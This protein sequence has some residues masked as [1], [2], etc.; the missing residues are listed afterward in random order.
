[1]AG[2]NQVLAGKAGA[3]DAVL[4]A[5]RAHIGN[6]GMSEKA[7]WA[8]LNICVNGVFGVDCDFGYICSSRSSRLLLVVIFTDSPMCCNLFFSGLCI[9]VVDC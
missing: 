7:C 9:C 5:M 3:I 2:E 4:V 8:I 1:M 6:A